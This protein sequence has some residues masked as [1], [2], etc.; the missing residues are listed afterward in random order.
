[1]NDDKLASSYGRL[2][3]A[4][5]GKYRRERGRE[6]VDMY[7]EMAGPRSRPR[8]SDAVDLLLGGIRQWLR[9]LRL[10][11]LADA[12]PTAAVFALSTLTALSVYL[13]VAFELRGGRSTDD[14]GSFGPFAT[15]FACAYLGW[16]VTSVVA[17]VSPGRLARISA[18]VTLVL[19]VAGVAV[20]AVHAP[21]PDL[22]AFFPLAF[23]ALGLVALPLPANPSRALRLAP[24]VV[25]VVAGVA[26]KARLPLPSASVDL[27][28]GTT[29]MWDPP[30]ASYATCC[31][32]RVPATYALHLAAVALI[33][34]AVVHAL[35]QAARG[36]ARGA[37]TLLIVATPA[38]ALTSVWL[39][40][41]VEPFRQ[42]A[43]RITGWN[44]ITVCIVGLLGMAITA[45]A[46]PLIISLLA[47]LTP[48]I[49]RFVRFAG[50]GWRTQ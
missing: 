4:Y 30:A 35:A 37:W 41:N 32:Y 28:N 45:V 3:F 24:L 14:P 2:L 39:H 20:R 48:L 21:V 19:V 34:A 44:E 36:R 22:P 8:L 40:D 33:A 42:F 38:T 49:A 18:G 12:L 16:L 43:Y 11:G 46:A 10:G 27:V 6:L 17:A 31:D 13:L 50:G 26:A 25:A 47:H 9:V 5:P 29:S 23:L 7:L 1:M 15:F